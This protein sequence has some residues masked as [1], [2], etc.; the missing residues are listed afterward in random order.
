MAASAASPSEPVTRKCSVA[1]CGAFTRITFTGRLASVQGPS[2]IRA[3][4][5]FAEKP[6]A[7]CVSLTDGRA[8][9]PTGLTRTAEAI[10]GTEASVTLLAL[11]SC[12][13]F[14]RAPLDGRKRR[15]ARGLG[16]RDHG[17]LDHRGIA[18]D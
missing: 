7:H 11:A 15:T 8:W 5:I 4:S 9:S 14:L 13:E 12:I 1:P 16:R 17:S 10:S 2:A 6:F 18:D 3:N